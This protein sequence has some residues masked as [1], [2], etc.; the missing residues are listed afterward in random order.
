[1]V[2]SGKNRDWLYEVDMVFNSLYQ[3][4]EFLDNQQHS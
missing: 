3:L 4:A 2:L 1:M